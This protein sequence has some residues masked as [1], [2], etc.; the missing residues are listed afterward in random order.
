MLELALL[1]VLQVATT[2][3]NLPPPPEPVL[4]AQA[5]QQVDCIATGSIASI[6]RDPAV[7]GGPRLH[8]VVKPSEMLW[9]T[10]VSTLDVVV[11]AES[12]GDLKV[13]A[14]LLCL[15]KRTDWRIE[16]TVDANSDHAQNGPGL[17]WVPAADEGLMPLI[18]QHS[19]ATGPCVERRGPMFSAVDG[20]AR[21]GTPNSLHPRASCRH[22]SA[23]LWSLPLDH[24]WGVGDGSLHL[25]RERVLE[26]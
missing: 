24:R 4:S 6:H 25:G 10:Q 11:S 15:L 14:S 12:V 17:S 23:L 2:G 5:W 13:G 8:L 21:A 9:G 1:C 20:R 18:F 19:D 26:R 7:D 22:R 16:C 3:S